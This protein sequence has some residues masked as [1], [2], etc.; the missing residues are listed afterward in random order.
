MYSRYPN[1]INVPFILFLVSLGI[2]AFV[3]WTEVEFNLAG[4]T[5]FVRRPFRGQER[6]DL[7]NLVQWEELS[8]PIRGQSRRNLVMFFE[9]EKRV[10]ISNTNSTDQ[11][12]IIYRHL[13]KEFSG[14]EKFNMTELQE[15]AFESIHNFLSEDF[16]SG[17]HKDLSSDDEKKRKFSIRIFRMKIEGSTPDD[18]A[19]KLLE[20][21]TK[22][23]AQH[24]TLNR[25]KQ[26]AD[27]IVQ[28]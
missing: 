27:R 16:Y 2:I 25:C 26:V 28:I 18:I 13:R 4:N 20:F 9:R 14:I 22:A 17:A 11:Y 1:Q 3:F 23:L 5:L 15:I 21:K 10:D 24:E 19:A 7:K 6:F 8:Y 12:D